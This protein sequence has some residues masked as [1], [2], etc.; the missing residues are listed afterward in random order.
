MLLAFYFSKKKKQVCQVWWAI[1]KKSHFSG[2]ITCFF[3]YLKVDL[4]G[5]LSRQG[6]DGKKPKISRIKA[7]IIYEASKYG[8]KSKKSWIFGKVFSFQTWIT[9]YRTILTQ[10]NYIYFE[11]TSGRLFENNKIAVFNIIKNFKS[12]SNTEH[13]QKYWK[14]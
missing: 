14:L 3:Y 12:T 9:H 4:Y 1:W 2:L 5:S 7:T 6:T 13:F 11:S 10:W 8:K